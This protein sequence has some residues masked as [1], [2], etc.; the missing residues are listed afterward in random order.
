MS[1]ARFALTSAFALWTAVWAG[2]GCSLKQAAPIKQ[3]YLVEAKRTDAPRAGAGEGVLRVRGLQVNAPFEGRG[4][5][6]RRGEFQYQTDF[7][8]EFLVPPRALFSEQTAQWLTASGQFK[9]VE[10]SGH[11]ESTYGL[12]GTVSALYGDFRD[13]QAPKAVLALQFVMTDERARS[14]PAFWS[15]GYSEAVALERSTP[16]ALA[17]GWSAAL[18]KI[19]TTLEKDLAKDLTGRP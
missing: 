18:Q 2:G 5:V 11:T 1:A 7:Y 13:K 19:L 12:E 6:Y 10:L 8:H 15:H 9:L 3:A 16:E 14:T 4:F 17:A